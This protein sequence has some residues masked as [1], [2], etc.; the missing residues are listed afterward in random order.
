MKNSNYLKISIFIAIVQ[1][2]NALEFMVIAPIASYLIVPF[3][4]NINQIG[5]LTGSYTFCAIFSGFIGYLFLDRFNQKN[6]LLMCIMFLGIANALTIY[7]TSLFMFIAIRL[8][9][10]FFGEL[11]GKVEHDF[12]TLNYSH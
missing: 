8:L 3:H 9:S 7:C 2:I 5:I 1:F 11:S 12:A 4:I 6:L 10:G